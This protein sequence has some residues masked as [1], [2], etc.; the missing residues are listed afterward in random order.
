V[1]VRRP[2]KKFERKADKGGKEWSERK[3][4]DDDFNIHSG[5]VKNMVLG[6]GN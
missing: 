5:A 3:A 2:L 1:K 6:Q 4:K